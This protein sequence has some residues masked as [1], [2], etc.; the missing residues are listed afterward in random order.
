[1]SASSSKPMSGDLSTEASV[2]S[3]SGSIAARPAA[4]RSITAIWSLS[5]SRSAPAAF[6]FAALSARI[7]ASKKALRVRTRIMTS[8]SRMRRDF[9][10]IRVDH[11]LA[12]GGLEPAFDHFGD[13]PG[14]DH[15]RVILGGRIERHAPV[16]RVRR[17]R[18]SDRRPEF[19]HAFQVANG[20]VTWR[21]L[22]GG[23]DVAPGE[24][25]AEGHVDGVENRLRRP[26]REGQRHVGERPLRLA[27]T[28]GE[29]A[30]HFREHPGAAPWKAKIDC[31]SSPTAKIVRSLGR[32]PAPAKNSALM[33]ARMP[34]CGADASCAS[35]SSR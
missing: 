24:L 26:E 1:M 28:L 14:E 22:P 12:R 20:L 13:P 32:A 21:L 6:T 10:R 30:L 7:I 34:H 8:L 29:T 18:W 27:V 23:R 35:S 17:R 19:D 4:M 2:R 5:L 11:P 15:R 31:F 33:A 9:T 3:S 16:F 25:V